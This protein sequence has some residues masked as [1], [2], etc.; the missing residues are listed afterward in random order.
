MAAGF[1]QM[2]LKYKCHF[3]TPSYPS[4]KTGLMSHQ[5][6]YREISG[7]YYL[8]VQQRKCRR[9]SKIYYLLLSKEFFIVKQKEIHLE[10]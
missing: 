7:I 6:S 5:H 2:I 1:L 9:L 10:Y 8:T 3:P 4:G